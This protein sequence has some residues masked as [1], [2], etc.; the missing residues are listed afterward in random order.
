MKE[1]KLD[2][3]IIEALEGTPASSPEKNGRT[4]P[5][6]THSIPTTLM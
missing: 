6:V 5:F 1:L 3:T 4:A 2:P